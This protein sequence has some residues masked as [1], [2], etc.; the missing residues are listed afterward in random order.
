MISTNKSAEDLNT[1]AST[2]TAADA[3]ASTGTSAKLD[4]R[5]EAVA[6]HP[7]TP[8]PRLGQIGQGKGTPLTR[9]QRRR[10]LWVISLKTRRSGFFFLILGRTA[11]QSVF[12]N[13]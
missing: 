12:V 7:D 2:T 11:K 13:H 1:P 6:H 4:P 9:S 5:S 3:A 8:S 10:A